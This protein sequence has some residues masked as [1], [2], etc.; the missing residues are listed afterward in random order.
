M[1]FIR[2]DK[3]HLHIYILKKNGLEAPAV[4]QWVKNLTAAVKLLCRCKD[5]IFG[6][7][8]WFKGSGVARA[9]V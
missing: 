3:T 4:V 9:A 6:P 7:A 5:L 2:K 1:I 8:Q